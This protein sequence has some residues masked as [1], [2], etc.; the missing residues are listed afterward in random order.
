MT[1]LM[2]IG[3][4]LGRRTRF[5]PVVRSEG[6]YRPRRSAFTQ[7]QRNSVEVETPLLCLRDVVV[8]RVVVC[9]SRFAFRVEVLLEQ[10]DRL[11]RKTN[12]LCSALATPFVACPGCVF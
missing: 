10:L 4:D 11:F 1:R 8:K 6:F 3:I 2:G 12:I 9:I 5:L 7:E